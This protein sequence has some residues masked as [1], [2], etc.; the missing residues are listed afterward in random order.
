MSKRWIARSDE[1][2]SLTQPAG[3][4]LS[5]STTVRAVQPLMRTWRVSDDA[6]SEVAS[7]EF[8]A[9]KK[10]GE[11]TGSARERRRP[12]RRGRTLELGVQAIAGGETS[13]RLD[14]RERNFKVLLLL[15]EL[16]SSRLGTYAVSKLR[17][18]LQ[19]SS[20]THEFRVTSEHDRL[21][22][23]GRAPRE[24]LP[25]LLGDERHE[26]V[27]ETHPVVED[28]VERVLRRTT[29]DGRCGGV[30][31]ELDSLLRGRKGISK[32]FPNQK[33]EPRTM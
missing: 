10:T 24:A 5:F 12:A 31:D 13:H 29:S 21:G 6:L 9:R 18:T 19:K 28:R 3:I 7:S 1:M 30:G 22:E 33:R 11:R 8:L 15:R 20:E 14:A 4:S 25:E 17:P 23:V 16:A 2:F 26:G 32:S 27:E